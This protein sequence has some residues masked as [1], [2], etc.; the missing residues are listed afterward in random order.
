MKI[1]II[2]I[3]IKLLTVNT[4]TEIICR[5]RICFINTFIPSIWIFK[6]INL[7]NFIN[8]WLLILLLLLYVIICNIII[9]IICTIY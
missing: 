6:C 2:K 3:F 5:K 1:L 9:I 4:I 8:F 7:V